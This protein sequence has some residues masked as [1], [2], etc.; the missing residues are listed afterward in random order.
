MKRTGL[1]EPRNVSFEEL[2]SWKTVFYDVEAPGV[3]SANVRAHWV[4]A[5]TW[6][7]LH[8]SRTAERSSGLRADLK[9]VLKAMTVSVKSRF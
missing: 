1:P 3:V 7:D 4:E 2:G 5:G 8:L 9:N 6:I